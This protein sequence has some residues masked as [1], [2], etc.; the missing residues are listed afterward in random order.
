MGIPTL[1]GFMTGGAI[2][3]PPH[4]G[5]SEGLSQALNRRPIRKF[6][7]NYVNAYVTIQSHGFSAGARTHY[8]PA[9]GVRNG[10]FGPQHTVT[11]LTERVHSGPCPTRP[12][13]SLARQPVTAHSQ[14]INCRQ[15]VYVSLTGDFFF[16]FYI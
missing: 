16:F 11:A 15:A 7:S 12:A 5:T 9:N 1:A 3:G 14:S 10:L 2:K 13:P 4:T 8:V 6:L